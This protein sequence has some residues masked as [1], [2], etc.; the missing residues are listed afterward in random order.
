MFLTFNVFL[1]YVMEMNNTLTT[2]KANQKI[3]LNILKR[4]KNVLKGNVLKG[5][6]LKGM[7]MSSWI[8]VT[9]SCN[10]VSITVLHYV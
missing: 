8:S 1:S 5:N 6:V 3:L 9:F 7:H 4:F 2:Y 10:R